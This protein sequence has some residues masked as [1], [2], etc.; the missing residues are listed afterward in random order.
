MPLG[1]TVTGVQFDYSGY[2]IRG[3]VGLRSKTSLVNS[4]QASTS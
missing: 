2:G 4:R 1:T 3:L